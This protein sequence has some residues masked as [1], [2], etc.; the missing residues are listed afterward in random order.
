MNLLGAPGAKLGALPPMPVLKLELVPVLLSPKVLLPSVV[1]R[2][3]PVVTLVGAKRKGCGPLDDM[4][5][6]GAAGARS[7]S[8]AGKEEEVEEMEVEEGEASCLSF[9]FG[10]FGKR[11]TGARA[12]VKLKG[13]GA[14]F[15]R[16]GNGTALKTT[17][18]ETEG[19]EAA[20]E[21]VEEGMEG[22]NNSGGAAG[23]AALVV[24]SASPR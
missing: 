17:V 23:G 19:W 14:A 13:E 16:G 24:A 21:E 4:G 7:D 6:K 10:S 5:G 9:C 12:A 2:L 8:G 18:V 1:A 22:A 15:A 11:M 3:V 20:G